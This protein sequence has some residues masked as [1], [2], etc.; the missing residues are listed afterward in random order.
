MR[1][2]QLG[3]GEPELAIVGAVHG[4]EPCGVRAIDR[5]LETQPEVSRPVELIVANER[6]L[7]LGV[8]YV[9]ADLNRSFQYV[10]PDAHEAKVADALRAR[11]RNKTILSIHST[12]STEDPFAIV[13]G[14]DEGVAPIVAGLS[15]EAVVDAGPPTEGRIFDTS[16]TVVEVEAG[17]QG[18][19]AAADNA[20]QLA[21]EFLFA[22][23]ALPGTVDRRAHPL[24]ELGSA[25]SKP[26][27]TEYEIRARNF[28]PV[29]EGEV[30]ATADD[31]PIRADRAFWPV[32]L[33]AEG[34]QDILGYRGQKEGTVPLP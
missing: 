34:Y 13:S 32:L 7:Q 8:R 16:S 10:A 21:E 9:D 18:S 5:L 25:I 14:L 27:A 22:T 24:F 15:V 1:V 23:G 2:D 33:S 17:L 20:T 12:Q 29:A 31:R 6:A 11:I 3:T 19:E 26:P 28:T 4:D 30:I